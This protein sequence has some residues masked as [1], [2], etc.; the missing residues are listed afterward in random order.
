MIRCGATK[1]NGDP[2]TLA[3]NGSNGLCWAH[4]PKQAERRR[5]G[6]AKGGRGKA[7]RE[8]LDL[9]G[10]LAAL[11]ADVLSGETEP[12]VGAVVTQ[13]LNARTRLLETERKIREAEELER[14]LEEV[15]ERVNTR[16]SWWAGGNV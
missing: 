14:R 12:K 10:Q 3:S 4:D 16:P 8:L 13:I 7:G 11:A 6:Q 1:R 2:C 15:E 9:K 5:R